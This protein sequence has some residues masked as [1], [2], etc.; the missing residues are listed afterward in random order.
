MALQTINIGASAQIT[1]RLE[2]ALQMIRRQLTL[3]RHLIFR[4]PHVL[5][6]V[7][8]IHLGSPLTFADCCGLRVPRLLREE[9]LQGEPSAE[10][11]LIA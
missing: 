10:N 9:L 8:L 4:T 7:E 2:T 3:Q 1:V 11:L 6:F 5:A